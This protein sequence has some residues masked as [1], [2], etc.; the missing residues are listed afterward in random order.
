MKTYNFR[1]KITKPTVDDETAANLL[2]EAGCTDATFGVSNGI[3]EI[4]FD[5]EGETLI[6]AM[7]SAM[8]D[9]RKA[10]IGSEVII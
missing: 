9:I 1:L 10:K 4:E 5:R 6:D 2:Y 3:Y 8:E 7:F